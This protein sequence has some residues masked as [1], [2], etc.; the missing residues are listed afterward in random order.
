MNKKRLYYND[1]NIYFNKSINLDKN[2]II[3]SLAILQKKIN[4]SF[5][6]STNIF[7]HLF[8]FKKNIDLLLCISNNPNTKH[9]FSFSHHIMDG[10]SFVLFCIEFY[11]LCGIETGQ[12]VLGNEIINK[13]INLC[14]SNFIYNYSIVNIFKFFFNISLNFSGSMSDCDENINTGLKINF[15]LPHLNSSINKTN[16]NVIVDKNR[17]KLTF[18]QKIC[19]IIENVVCDLELIPTKPRF[20][21]PVNIAPFHKRKNKYG[22]YLCIVPDNSNLDFSKNYFIVHLFILLFLIFPFKYLSQSHLENIVSFCFNQIDIVYSNIDA[23]IIKCSQSNISNYYYNNFD[24]LK[25]KNIN[26]SLLKKSG[27]FI[28]SEKHN[29]NT[30]SIIQN[31]T[32]S[33]PIFENKLFTFSCI[34]LSESINITIATKMLDKNRLFLFYKHFLLEYNKFNRI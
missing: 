1:V 15:S 31:I 33:A 18:N 32:Y 7:P 8:L 16:K 20:G 29:K 25:M 19:H 23:R 13:S 21:V 22:N 2:I 30:E 34:S 17:H 12:C 27:S 14:N 11:N 4:F 6:V 9:F 24:S 26:S 3:K 10:Y 28:Q 5:L